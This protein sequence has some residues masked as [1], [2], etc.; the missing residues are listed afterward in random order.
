VRVQVLAIELGN[1]VNSIMYTY[2]RGVSAFGKHD[3]HNGR[4]ARMLLSH[5]TGE[6]DTMN[7]QAKT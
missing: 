6:S 1:Q 4:L 5:W 7:A 2:A 3:L